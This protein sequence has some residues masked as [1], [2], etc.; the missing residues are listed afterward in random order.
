MLS[1]TKKD[2]LT[3]I[4]NAISIIPDKDYF[5]TIVNNTKKIHINA[6]ELKY[7]PSVSK[8]PT[9]IVEFVLDNG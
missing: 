2:S 5:H 9:L 7:I 8:I 4:M 1:D 6:Y 3:K